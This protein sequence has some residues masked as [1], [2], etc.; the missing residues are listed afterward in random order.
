MSPTPADGSP[1]VWPRQALTE[2]LRSVWPAAQLDVVPSTPS[3]NTVL[4]DW[5]REGA[6]EGSPR[7]LVAEAQ[8]A[9]RGRLGRTWLA[10]AGASLTFSLALPLAPGD[11][12]GLSL[13]VGVALAQ[14]L[15]PRDGPTPA[16][17]IGLKWPNDLWLVDRH[18][19]GRKLGG[20]LVE[21]VA[22]GAVR[23][24]VLGVGL[25]VCPRVGDIPAGVSLACLAEWLPGITVPDALAR[26]VSPLAQAL[27]QFESTGFAPFAPRYAERDLLRGRAITLSHHPEI[28]HGIAEG[29]ADD[30]ALRVRSAQGLSLIYSGEVSVRPDGSPHVPITPLEDVA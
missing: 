28:T 12:S 22:L 24:V 14:A 7:L 8:T 21:T 2:A 20:I 17:R 1:L 23:W 9:G 5:V 6:S 25:N 26:V 3:T 16:V 13:A 4:M 11:W 27:K 15:D 19:P 18:A 10:Q 29:V 30:G